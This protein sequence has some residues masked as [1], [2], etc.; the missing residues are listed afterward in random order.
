MFAD[1]EGNSPIASPTIITA[2]HVCIPVAVGGNP[3]CLRCNEEVSGMNSANWVYWNLT[4]QTGSSISGGS[5]TADTVNSQSGTK[6]HIPAGTTAG[7]KFQLCMNNNDSGKQTVIP[8]LSANATAGQKRHIK[9]CYVNYGNEDITIRLQNDNNGGEGS[10]IVPANGYAICEFDV[11][12][13]AGSNWFWL[14]VDSNVSS[15]VD[16]GVYGCFYINDGE[17]SELSINTQATKLSFTEGETFSSNGLVLDA[18]LP[19]TTP[20]TVYVQSGYTT[21]LDGHTF[22]A[23]D[24]GTKT[25]TVTFAGKTVTYDITVTAA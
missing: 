13:V 15:D 1:A 2:G 17:L 18:L 22:T 8:N 11:T 25:V 21:D 23:E 19:S 3:Y 24:V 9:V 4:T 7:S 5:I 20:K 10:V 12:N 16:L 6:V 14:N